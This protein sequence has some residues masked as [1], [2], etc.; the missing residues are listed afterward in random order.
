[1]GGAPLV[2]LCVRNPLNYRA[3]TSRGTLGLGLHCSAVLATTLLCN[4]AARPVQDQFFTSEKLTEAAA[5]VK[6]AVDGGHP[7][8][9]NVGSYASLHEAPWSLHTNDYMQVEIA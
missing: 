9:M 5:A 8:L 4:P 6:A 3:P 1:M 7:M 2:L